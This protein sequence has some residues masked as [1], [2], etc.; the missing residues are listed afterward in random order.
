[1]IW[2]ALKW[3]SVIAT[4]SCCCQQDVELNHADLCSLSLM[5]CAGASKALE[6]LIDVLSAMAR[7]LEAQQN[8]STPQLVQL[9]KFL[10]KLL[11]SV[12]RAERS[13]ELLAA[14]PG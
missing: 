1:M 8:R 2:R 4:Q 12:G 6:P 10:A 11:S 7:A 14:F 13:C 3:H 9:A 5:N